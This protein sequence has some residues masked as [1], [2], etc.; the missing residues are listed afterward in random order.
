MRHR[1]QH[2]DDGD[3]D[4]PSLLPDLFLDRDAVMFSAANISHKH[5]LSVIR[6][7]RSHVLCC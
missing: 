5:S 1:E 3:D 7:R 4:L 6:L 2:R